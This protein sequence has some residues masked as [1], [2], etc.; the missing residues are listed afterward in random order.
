MAQNYITVKNSWGE[1]AG[2]QGYYYI[3]YSYFTNGNCMGG[4]IY[5]LRPA[6][7]EITLLEKIVN[8]M[9]NIIAKLTKN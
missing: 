3:P 5:Q 4:W 6:N 2:D 1:I 8:L 7:Y 9:Q